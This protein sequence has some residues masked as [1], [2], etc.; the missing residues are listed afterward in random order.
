MFKLF[1][2]MSECANN[3]IIILNWQT[4]FCVC[5]YISYFLRMLDI[6]TKTKGRILLMNRSRKKMPMSV[7]KTLNIHLCA[8]TELEGVLNEF[9]KI[10]FYKERRGLS[11]TLLYHIITSLLN[12]E[13]ETMT[14]C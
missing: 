6:G 11:R 3:Q 9:L 12:N 13:L 14:S 4:N 2:G 7:N 5:V 10:L 8:I 1:N